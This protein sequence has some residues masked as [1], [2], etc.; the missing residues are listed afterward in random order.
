MNQTF[1]LGMGQML[2]EGGQLDANLAR[3]VRMIERAAGE[4]CAMVLLPECLD[5]GWMFPAARELA[6]PVPGP[7]TEELAAG[8]RRWNVYVASGLT[9]RDGERLYNAAVLL[10]PEGRIL[11]KHRKVNEL[12]FARAFYSTGC[13]IGVADTDIGRI[14]LNICADNFPETLALGQAAGLMG[15]RLLASPC[16]W[17]MEPNHDNARQPYGGLWLGSY[18]ALARQFP[19]TIAGASNVGWIRGG[20]WD[21]HKCIGC[22]LAVGPGGKVLAQGPYGETAEALLVVAVE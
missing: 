4:G 3:A 9:E 1:K 12:D 6:G 18:T 17:A 8:A 21:G 20:P 10:S 7:V 5:L 19:M 14:G 2:V 13:S 15:A 16:A 22:S 11:L